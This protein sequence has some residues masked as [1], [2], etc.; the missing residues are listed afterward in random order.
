MIFLCRFKRCKALRTAMFKRYINSIITILKKR[1][2][3]KQYK[4]V[5]YIK[6]NDDLDGYSS[7][8]LA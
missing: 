1:N 8:S 6:G 2:I 7:M 3:S 5:L 4:Q